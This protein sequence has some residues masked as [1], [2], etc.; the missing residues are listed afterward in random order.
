MDHATPENQG[1]PP[2]SPPTA[3]PPAGAGQPFTGPRPAP[4]PTPMHPRRV[5]GGVRLSGGIVEGPT[6][7]AAQRWMR[8]VE[9]AAPGANLTEGLE[10]AKLGQIKRVSVAPGRVEA[11]IQG[12]S[13]RPYLT[14]ITFGRLTDSEWEHVARVMAEGA[15]YSAKLLAGELPSNIEDAFGPLNLRLF[16]GEP[17]HLS[18]SCTCADF[19]VA[20]DAQAQSLAD[21]RWCKHVCCLSHIL[22]GRLANEPLLIFAL[23]GLEGAELLERLRD[24][25]ASAAVAPGDRVPVY[26]QHVP[27]ITDLPAKTLEESLATFWDAGPALDTLDLPLDRPKLSHPLLRRLGPSPLQDA[28]FPLVGLLASCYDVISDEALRRSTSTGTG[29]PGTPEAE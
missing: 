21:P 20:S 18:V 27:G 11:A 13:D 22:A 10:Y 14:Q 3:A 15:V 4:R 2:V 28:P 12:R 6:L 7:W 29:E 24:Q 25:R 1:P 5:R 23:R 16:P 19:R 9:A 17:S 8:V 26:Q